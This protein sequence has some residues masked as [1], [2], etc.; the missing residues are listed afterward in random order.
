[1]GEPARRLR[2]LHVVPTYWPAVRYGGPIRS[3]HGLA[4]AL[5]LL[6]H[7]V[8]VYTTSMDGAADLRVP[9]NTPVD[10]DGVKVWY[11]P[12]PRLRRLHVAP[13]LARQLR[14]DVAGF[15]VVHLHSVFLWPTWMAARAAR[16][17]GIPYIVAPRGMLVRN[18]I[19]RKSRW[20]KQAW[21]ALIE[22][23]TLAQAA[24]LHVTAHGEADELRA[25]NFLAAPIVTIPNGVTFPQAPQLL[26]EGPFKALPPRYALFLSRISWKKGLDRLIRAWQ[27]VPDLPLVIAG[28]DDEGYQC[29]LEA[30]ARELG[31]AERVLFVGPASDA[32]KWAL[33]AQAEVFVLP[34]YSE[35]FGMV[36]AEAMA[37][38]C[39][40]IVTPDVGAGELVAQAG[41]GMISSGEPLQLAAAVR[42]LLADPAARLRQGEAGR[43]FARTQLS[44]EGIAQRTC[45][46]YRDALQV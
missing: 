31:I 34:S 43:Q 18:I 3:V 10:V 40:V 1:V 19:R 33:Y 42:Q 28:N 37:M 11:F 7:D 29:K 20:L 8:H 44:W 32:D 9:L 12:V 14:R 35:N 6:G 21:V 46:M 22:R 15:D 39:P 26:S 24:R 27:L 17:A 2:I 5:T 16:R 4:I 38:G 30:L 45:E 23:R 41:A 25:Q 36:V 13:G